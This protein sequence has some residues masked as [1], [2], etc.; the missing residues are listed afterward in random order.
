M[1][2]D[3]SH[4]QHLTVGS[5]LAGDFPKFTDGDVIIVS[6]TGMVW[7]LHSNTLRSASPKLQEMINAVEGRK[8]TDKL[9]IDGRV[10]R[11]KIEMSEWSEKPEDTRFRDLTVTVCPQPLFDYNKVLRPRDFSHIINYLLVRY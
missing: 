10:E 4:S 5:S 6:G 7:K 2:S 11:W 3:L 1:S 9:Q 8:I